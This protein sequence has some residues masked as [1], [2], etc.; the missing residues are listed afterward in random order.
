MDNVD[1]SAYYASDISFTSQLPTLFCE[2]EFHAKFSYLP[3]WLRSVQVEYR[4][5]DVFGRNLCVLDP[6]S[7]D[8]E[9]I[10]SK[11][12]LRAWVK[13]YFILKRMYAI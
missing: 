13:R 10:S 5:S 11:Y 2:A 6:C 8:P 3:S 1:Y 9:L 7:Q 12:G 4:P